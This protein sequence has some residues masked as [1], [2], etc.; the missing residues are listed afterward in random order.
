M[1]M[2]HQATEQDWA[3]TKKSRAFLFRF[4]GRFSTT[5]TF[6]RKGSPSGESQRLSWPNRRGCYFAWA[7]PWLCWRVSRR[8][9][10]AAGEPLAIQMP[11]YRCANSLVPMYWILVT[12]FFTCRLGYFPQGYL[13]SAWELVDEAWPNANPQEVEVNANLHNIEL[14]MSVCIKFTFLAMLVDEIGSSHAF[15]SVLSQA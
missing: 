14:E 1:K 2:S 15:S 10:D 13:T 4:L 5:S 7:R 8:D 11:F 6:S 9:G 12:R 3:D